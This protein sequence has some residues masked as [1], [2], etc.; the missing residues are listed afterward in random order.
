MANPPCRQPAVG[1]LLLIHQSCHNPLGLHLCTGA[2]SALQQSAV[3][4]QQHSKLS[5][6]QVEDDPGDPNGLLCVAARDIEPGEEV[7][8]EASGWRSA[9]G[10]V[11]RLHALGDAGLATG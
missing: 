2:A 7:R 4:L 5:C 9:P 11:G 3:M 8:Q 6:V 10:R 1:R